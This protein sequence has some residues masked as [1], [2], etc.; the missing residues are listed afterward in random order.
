MDA[1][2]VVGAGGRGGGSL[3]CQ[4]EVRKGED[5]E[6]WLGEYRCY[7]I[8]FRRV[9][10]GWCYETGA[11]QVVKLDMCIHSNGRVV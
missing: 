4:Q 9:E 6:G 7:W 5:G 2:G 1:V 8:E 10:R 11:G 3:I